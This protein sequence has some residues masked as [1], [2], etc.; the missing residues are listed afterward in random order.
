MSQKGQSNGEFTN[1]PKLGVSQFPGFQASAKSQGLQRWQCRQSAQA[2]QIPVAVMAQ[3]AALHCEL[4]G[5]AWMS[6]CR[7]ENQPSAV[8]KIWKHKP[9]DESKISDSAAA[10]SQAHLNQVV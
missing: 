3:T 10:R 7:S 6:I 4:Q 2:H 1:G 8:D 9:N 5:D